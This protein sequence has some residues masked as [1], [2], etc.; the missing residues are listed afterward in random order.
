MRFTRAAI[1][2]WAIALITLAIGGIALRLADT[3]RTQSATLLHDANATERESKRIAAALPGSTLLAVHFISRGL[4]S[5][6]AGEQVN[7]ERGSANEVMQAIMDYERRG[8]GVI[9]RFAFAL[10]EAG[11]VSGN[12]ASG[13]IP[14]AQK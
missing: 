3:T 5:Q 4:A 9:S 6:G 11:R 2:L 14:A 7:I 10:P 13:S 1:A 8:H 12:V